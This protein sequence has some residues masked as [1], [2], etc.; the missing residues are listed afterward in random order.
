MNIKQS[1]SVI[2]L[3]NLGLPLAI[4]F[5]KAKIQI[6]AMD[7][8]NSKIEAL[9]AGSSPIEETGLQE[10]IDNLEINKYLFPTMS[11]QKAILESLASFIVVNT[12]SREDGS[13]NISDILKVAENIGKILSETDSFHVVVLVSTV[14]PQDS[15]KYIIPTLEQFSGKKCGIDF[16]FVYNPEFVALG[17]VIENNLH[18]DFRVI[19]ESDMKSGKIV[20][21]IYKQVSQDPIV[22]MNIVNAELTKIALNSFLTIKISFANTIAEIC[23]KL[24]GGNVDLVTKALGFDQRI[25]SKFLKAGL[26]YGGPCFP[27]DDKA[28]IALANRLNT[29]AYLAE[30]SN[31]VNNKQVPLA[32]NLIKNKLASGHIAILGL[33]YKPDV[34]YI[35]KSQ[36][37]EIAKI[38]AQDS[39]YKITVYDPQALHYAKEILA[40][41]VSYAKS[42][43]E[44]IYQNKVDLILILTPWKDFKNLDFA[45]KPVINF[46]DYI[47]QSLSQTYQ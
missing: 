34:P 14:S 38:L 11:L 37:F 2:G 7:I 19:G 6:F 47:D 43:Q 42:A 26:G 32:L 27:R 24:E 31:K 22:R 20:E 4:T 33:S 23:N 13:Y 44:A 39:N 30:A 16:G 46:W 12:P 9:N 5:A 8:D 45:E 15:N 41:T 17:S 35:D 10:A 21:N 25:S 36:A 40:E 1:L 18:P 3:G 29:Q 28:I